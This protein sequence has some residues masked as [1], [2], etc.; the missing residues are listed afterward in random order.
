SGRRCWRTSRSCRL[1]G[2]PRAGSRP[3]HSSQNEGLSGHAAEAHVRRREF[4]GALGGAMVAAARAGHASQ[5]P[6]PAPTSG[7][8][9][10][11]PGLKVGHFTDPRR[12]T[13]CTAV[14]FDEPAAAG[15]DYNGS[16]PGETQ[17]VLLQPVSPVDQIHAILLS[18]GGVWGIG[19]V[20]GAM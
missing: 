15:V 4:A 5:R 13:G 18:G 14:L 6:D 3:D 12:P 7:S 16:A 1:P 11:V 10:D 20:A 8:M 9:T 19:A 17:V 2:R